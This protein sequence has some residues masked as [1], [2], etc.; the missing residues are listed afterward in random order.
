MAA[1]QAAKLES[2]PDVNMGKVGEMVGP[3]FDNSGLTDRCASSLNLTWYVHEEISGWYSCYSHHPASTSAP[4]DALVILPP[5]QGPA[6]LPS[7]HILH[8]T[9]SMWIGHSKIKKDQLRLQTSTNQKVPGPGFLMKDINV[10]QQI[11]CHFLQSWKSVCV[12]FKVTVS[13]QQSLR[14]QKFSVYLVR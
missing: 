9:W 10:K 14:V 3:W 6:G 8:F 13:L 5:A 7:M 4:S 1:E 12:W 2:P 11:R